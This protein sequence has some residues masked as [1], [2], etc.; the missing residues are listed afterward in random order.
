MELASFLEEVLPH[1]WEF[2]SLTTVEPCH[3]QSIPKAWD[4]EMKQTRNKKCWYWKEVQNNTLHIGATRNAPLHESGCFRCTLR[5]TAPPIDCPNRKLGRVH[6][7]GFSAPKTHL[8]TLDPYQSQ[9]PILLSHAH[10]HGPYL[11]QS[12]NLL[13][14]AHAHS[15]GFFTFS[16]KKRTRGIKWAIPTNKW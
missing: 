9:S 7:S 11:F 12:P 5:A 13:S 14:H 6:N 15:R 1:Q 4:Q 10:A 16:C 8:I 2:V 3:L